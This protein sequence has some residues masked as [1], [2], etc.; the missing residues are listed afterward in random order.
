M[1][2]GVE[3][4]DL[5]EP[6]LHPQAALHPHL[7]IEGALRPLRPEDRGHGS[8]GVHRAAAELPLELGGVFVVLVEG[9]E[10][11]RL[12]LLAVVEES[13]VEGVVVEI[14]PLVGVAEGDGDGEVEAQ[15]GIIGIEVEGEQLDLVDGGAGEAGVEDEPPEEE[16]EA[17]GDDD[18]E[19]RAEELAAAGTTAF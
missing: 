4:P 17:G 13:G 12:D 2:L 6:K 10:R 7:E 5:D 16:D 9:R 8:T 11:R 3:V 19:E 15:G 14:D 18:L 1:E